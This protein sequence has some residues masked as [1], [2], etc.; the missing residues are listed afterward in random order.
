VRLR[1]LKL[2]NF[3]CYRECE[4]EL[5]DGIT[6]AV[7]PNGSGKTTLFEAAAWALFGRSRHEGDEIRCAYARQDEL[8]SVEVDFQVG[9][10][11]Y[12]L[13]R[14]QER[15]G[16]RA[17]L[18]G[19]GEP[20]QGAQAVT[21]QVG[22][23]LG[24]GSKIFFKSVFSRQKE[25]DALSDIGSTEREKHFLRMLGIDR[26][27]EAVARIRED[28]RSAE[29][30]LEGFRQKMKDP[31]QLRRDLE[32][33]EREFQEAFGL[34]KEKLRLEE[35]AARSVEEAEA[36]LRRLK[37]KI[38]SVEPVREKHRRLEEARRQCSGISEEEA[39]H[40]KLV[41]QSEA[42]EKRIE[43]RTNEV[44][45][46]GLRARELKTQGET[47]EQ[48]R[49]LEKQLESI[50][51][52][53][54]GSPC[55]TCRRPLGAELGQVRTHLQEEIRGLQERRRRF[56]DEA[57]AA[58]REQAGARDALSKEKLSLGRLRKDL[59]EGARRLA[60]LQE[61]RRQAESL[62]AEVARLGTF[63]EACYRKESEELRS[64]EDALPGLREAWSNAKEDRLNAQ[65]RTRLLQQEID[66]KKQQIR[67]EEESAEE[68]R[69][70]ERRS[71]E[72]RALDAVMS[73]FRRALTERIR[74]QISARA[75]HWLARI[76]GGR[77]GRLE[78]DPSYQILCAD[79]GSPRPLSWFSGGETDLIH[80]C[81]R[82]AISQVAAERGGGRLNL[83]VLDEVFAS[84][85]RRR[86]DDIL[87]ALREIGRDFQQ[88]LLITHDEELK[89]RLENVIEVS[90]EPGGPARA[91][92]L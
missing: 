59:Q 55:P 35:A 71:R 2:V 57:G 76:T 49:K 43:D 37:E 87:R 3:G 46:L 69:A 65:T 16:S 70:L 52:L 13:S 40:R 5:P 90:R 92:L 63:D 75:G 91:R 24:M 51:E 64:V 79:A 17:D 45:G 82:V 56:L 83:L 61:Y 42:L 21:E 20:V 47:Q 89:N 68:A 26:V 12:R 84:Q 41:E 78:L 85:D 72:L 32:A 10:Q 62:A 22:R 54:A 4:L 60:V 25:I 80:L 8:C 33:L 14:R 9:G 39:A 27:E 36:R 38:Q 66:R 74:P 6:G 1:R 50:E 11:A 29:S 67:E 31:E 30:R 15:R 58:E 48:E 81:L 34:E 73:G 77:L 88:I 53:R 7:G 86:R 23:I 18:E 19:P 44:N 28:A